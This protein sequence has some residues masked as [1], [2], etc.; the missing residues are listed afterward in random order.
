M[1]PTT[2]N[3]TGQKCLRKPSCVFSLSIFFF[4]AT[5]FVVLAG[6]PET[7]VLQVSKPMKMEQQRL[8]L[9]A[10]G[11][12][13]QNTETIPAK[14]FTDRGDGTVRDNLTG[15]VWLKNADCFGLKTW[16]E[17]LAECGK[18]ADGNCGLTDGSSAGDWR[19]PT[20]KELQSL[21]DFKQ[22]DPALPN[23]HPF[24][25]VQ[26]SSYWSATD[27]VNEDTYAW[28]VYTYFGGVF[29]NIKSGYYY[30]WPVRGKARCG[31]YCD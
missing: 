24:T 21:I 9:V 27:Y 2:R 3:N 14:R 16:S 8:R 20:V 31:N 7:A 15:L 26:S 10:Q 29:T 22:Y 5:S 23:G 28:H 1:V 25:K 11:S 6:H 17:A 19:L 12:E 4:L 13:P 18:L 30:V